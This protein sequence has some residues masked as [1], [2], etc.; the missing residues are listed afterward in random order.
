MQPCISTSS[1]LKVLRLTGF[2]GVKELSNILIEGRMPVLEKLVVEGLNW[3]CSLDQANAI[4]D[5][6]ALVHL[7]VRT[8][9]IIRFLLCIPTDRISRLKTFITDGHSSR[10]DYT[11]TTKLLSKFL[12]GMRGL[13]H[14]ELRCSIREL[15]MSM[16]KNHGDTLRFLGVRDYVR[17]Y[18][19]FG[20]IPQLDPD[21]LNFIG[22]TCPR[23]M[24]IQFD[25]TIK[26]HVSP[27]SRLHN[28]L[29]RKTAG[30]SIRPGGFDSYWDT[31]VQV[32][33][34]PLTS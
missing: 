24:E 5:F 8:S 17:H 19:Q 15:D 7:E 30:R 26:A 3:D 25:M 1:R 14:L 21:S 31:V 18:S 2:P 29:L 28:P 11:E 20:K 12:S 16:L 4:W 13:E 22:R 27:N 6:S 33:Q 34:K 32:S 9:A 10:N 23:L